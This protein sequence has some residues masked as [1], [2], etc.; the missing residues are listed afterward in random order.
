MVIKGNVP[1]N[2]IDR[3]R[4]LDGLIDQNI[5]VNLL[6]YRPDEI[7]KTEKPGGP[8]YFGHFQGRAG[9]LWLIPKRN[10]L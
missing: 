8:V 7:E 9:S 6:V 4:E 10:R 2:G 1:S 3:L 5:N